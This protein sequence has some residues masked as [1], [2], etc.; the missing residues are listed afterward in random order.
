[1]KSIP[2]TGLLL[3]ASLLALLL[4]RSGQCFYNSS[5][6][7]W[8]SREPL[9]ELDC[10]NLFAFLRNDAQNLFDPFGLLKKK[11]GVESFVVLWRPGSFKYPSGTVS[12]L[13]IIVKI[14][15]K[16]GGEYDPRCCEYKQNAYH[17]WTKWTYPPVAS[18]HDDD[19]PLHDDGFSRK[20]NDDG[21][22]D[23]SLPYFAVGDVPGVDPLQNGEIIQYQFTA[24]QIVYSPGKSFA[25]NPD[26]KTEGCECEKNDQVA[27]RG[28][29]TA[30]IEGTYPGPYR[31]DGVPADLDK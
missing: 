31:Y 22:T 1:M 16:N 20:D 3:I 12:M 2:K 13:N 26:K 19:P 21:N 7:R 14:Q 8:L 5:E 23:P 15:F 25:G 17:D 24:E 11:C 10:G 6:G 29:H 30:K 28:P 4:P 27:K 18:G 9:G